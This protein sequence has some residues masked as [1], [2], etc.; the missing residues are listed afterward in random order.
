MNPISKP[1]E[2]EITVL[3]TIHEIK[4][5]TVAELVQRLGEPYTV[6]DLIAYLK[7]LEKEKLLNKVQE[8]PL[9]YELSILGLVAIGILPE[10]AKNIVLPVSAEKC[11]LFCTGVGPDKF[12]KISACSLS[13]LGE[14]VRKVDVRSLEFHIPRGDIEN[15]AKDVLG[16]LELAEE[17]G[18]VG[19]LKLSGEM[20]RLRIL[21]VIDSRINQLSSTFQA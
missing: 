2:D 18:R 11:F 12:T 3:K 15:W 1:T 21:K 17:I 16:D 4:K 14:K 6:Q 8:N 5:A 13:D 19:R 10:K 7:L 9:A 20:L